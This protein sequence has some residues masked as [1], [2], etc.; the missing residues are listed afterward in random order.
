MKIMKIFPKLILFFLFAGFVFIC[1]TGNSF[2]EKKSATY[3]GP[4]KLDEFITGNSTPPD[5]LKILFRIVTVAPE[6][7]VWYNFINDDL[8]K[9]ISEVSNGLITGKLYAGG[10]LGDEADTIRKMQMHQLHGLGVTN[11]GATKM[12]PEFCILELPF[13]FDYEPELFWNGKY[14]QIDYI[15]EKTEPTLAKLSNKHGYQ[16]GGMAETCLNFIGSKDPIEKAEDL[17]KLD[18]WLWRGDRIREEI[19]KKLEFGSLLSTDLYNVSQAFSTNMIDS[20]WVGYN[21]AIVLQWWPYI[22]Y[23]TDYPI[24]GYESATAFF[25][26][27]M[28]DKLALFVDKWGEKYGIDPEN[29]QKELIETL[30][31][32]I[33]KKMRMMIRDQEKKARDALLSQGIKE[34]HIPESEL[35]ILREKVEPLYW[36]L[37]DK[38]YPKSLLEEILTYREEYRKL[39]KE[40]SLTDEWYDKGILPGGNQ[41][42]EWHSW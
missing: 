9:G 3:M 11:M 16:F 20:T 28:I 6:G 38:L 24:F 26:R 12:V 21:P 5:N 15:L 35:K 30:D 2:S 31:A 18:F 22:K 1:L 39:K 29:F 8:F 36:D 34:V 33:T 4:W 19:D 23:T 10:V 17:K 7:S 27:R 14:T 40:G 41:Y 42:D 32:L 25:D 13:L 37:A